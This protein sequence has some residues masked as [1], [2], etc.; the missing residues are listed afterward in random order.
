M[1]Y[2]KHIQNRDRE[3]QCFRLGQ[4]SGTFE[5]EFVSILFKKLYTTCVI[6][7]RSFVSDAIKLSIHRA[8]N[9]QLAIILT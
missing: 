7:F 4:F 5:P 1:I 9:V 3:A 2:T 8:S 6:D